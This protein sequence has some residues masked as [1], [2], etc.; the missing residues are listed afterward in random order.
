[1][2]R[3]A[4]RSKFTHPRAFN[5]KPHTANLIIIIFFNYI[6]IARGDKHYIR[7]INRFKPVTARLE[8]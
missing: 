5:F 4:I 6:L 1:M 2:N 3:R 8:K 7:F